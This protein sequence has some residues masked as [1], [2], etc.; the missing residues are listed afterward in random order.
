[1]NYA[2]KIKFLKDQLPDGRVK[3]LEKKEVNNIF[4]TENPF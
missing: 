4:I 2:Q 1:M 3:F